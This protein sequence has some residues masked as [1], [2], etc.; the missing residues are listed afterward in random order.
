MLPFRIQ[1]WNEKLYTI[2]YSH[3][4]RFGYLIF[5][6]NLSKRKHVLLRNARQS[7][8]HKTMVECAMKNWIGKMEQ[9]FFTFC[10]FF[11]LKILTNPNP[12]YNYDLFVYNDT[13]SFNPPRLHVP[14]ASVFNSSGAVVRRQNQSTSFGRQP[15]WNRCV[16][17]PCTWPSAR[18]RPVPQASNSQLPR[19]RSSSRVDSSHRLCADR[20]RRSGTNSVPAGAGVRPEGSVRPPNCHR[21]DG[22]TTTTVPSVYYR[23]RYRIDNRWFY[24]ADIATMRPYRAR[25]R[26]TAKT[27]TFMIDNSWGG[28]LW[29]IFRFCIS[30]EE[31]LK[32][33]VRSEEKYRFP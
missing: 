21:P 4:A 20:A 30:I 28:L 27:V 31:F 7:T 8:C 14:T 26:T 3:G 11:F 25:R 9:T 23:R 19:L 32:K 24:V 16:C 1:I 22:G 17:P 2:Q 12:I 6:R 29:I 33:K 18:C 13:V 10:V 15:R 5:S